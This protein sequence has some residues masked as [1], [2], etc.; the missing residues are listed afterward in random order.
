MSKSVPQAGH[1]AHSLSE[2]QIQRV[3]GKGTFPGEQGV[4]FSTSFLPTPTGTVS[5]KGSL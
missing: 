4:R 3:S 5:A 2:R 1:L